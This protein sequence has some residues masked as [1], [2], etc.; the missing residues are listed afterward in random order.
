MN[1]EMMK[2]AHSLSWKL[3][4]TNLYH[5]SLQLENAV[6]WWGSCPVFQYSS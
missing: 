5:Y 1:D 4:R 2:Q 3:Q 6:L